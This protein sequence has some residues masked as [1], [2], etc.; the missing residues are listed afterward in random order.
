MLVSTYL[1]MLLACLR[2]WSM[3]LEV[4]EHSRTLSVRAT[5]W[6]DSRDSP[7]EERK[8]SS[9]SIKEEVRRRNEK[10]KGNIKK[11]ERNEGAYTRKEGR[12]LCVSSVV[13]LPLRAHEKIVRG[14]LFHRDQIVRASIWRVVFLFFFLSIQS[15]L[16]F[17][18]LSYSRSLVLFLSSF[19]LG[20]CPPP[21]PPRPHM[22]CCGLGIQ[23]VRHVCTCRERD[24]QGCL[25][26]YSTHNE[27]LPPSHTSMGLSRRWLSGV[28]LCVSTGLGVCTGCGRCHSRD[29]SCTRAMAG[30][31]RTQLALPTLP[32][33]TVPSFMSSTSALR[34]E[35]YVCIG[36]CR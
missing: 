14:L 12:S 33:H 27:K 26:T 36:T 24:R 17:A 6:G 1:K 35:M 3:S 21:P 30:R 13:C 29:S 4:R 25:C 31:S 5:P 7:K 10:E 18:G 11:V 9:L 32:L 28:C 15:R 2:V 20:P 34:G 19:L 8:L 16:L 23:P 22:R